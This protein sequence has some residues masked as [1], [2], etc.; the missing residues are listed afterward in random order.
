M[1]LIADIP[2]AAKQTGSCTA[3]RVLAVSRPAI[4]P[5]CELTGRAAAVGMSRNFERFAARSSVDDSIAAKKPTC[6]RRGAWKAS[7]PISVES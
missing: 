7:H 4:L 6:Q 5:D 3:L 2:G 1:S